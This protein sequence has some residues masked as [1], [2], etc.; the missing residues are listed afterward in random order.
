MIGNL[1]TK[2]QKELLKYSRDRYVNVQSASSSSDFFSDSSK[3]SSENESFG[4]E[5]FEKHQKKGDKFSK[6]IDHAFGYSIIKNMSLDYT[7]KKMLLDQY[8]EAKKAEING[9]LEQKLAQMMNINGTSQSRFPA[10]E[11]GSVSPY[12]YRLRMS[13][14]SQK[15]NRGDFLSQR[16]VKDPSV[17][18]WKKSMIKVENAELS[19]VVPAHDFQRQSYKSATTYDP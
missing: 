6:E 13:E 4:D 15:T 17:E 11:G 7:Q 5:E 8:Q 3:S 9:L 18:L 19:S 12:E 1:L 16:S 14:K 10:A 2:E